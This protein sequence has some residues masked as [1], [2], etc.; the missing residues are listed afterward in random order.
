MTAAP[1]P[2]GRDQPRP[3]RPE[4]AARGRARQ[5]ARQ[6][7]RWAGR[8]ALA[9]LALTALGA[10]LLAIAVLGWSYPVAELA[11]ERGGPLL[12]TDRNGRLLRSVPGP[13]HRPGRAAWVP[14]ERVPSHALLAVIASEDRRFYEHSGV[15]VLGVLRAAWLDVRAGRLAY[16]GSTITMQLVRMVDP[17]LRTRG[18][19]SKIAQAVQAL[20]LERAVDKRFLLEQYLNRAY[21]GNG[22][23][24]LEAAARLYFDKPAASLSAGEATLLAV[25]PRAPSAYDPVRHLDAALRRRAHVLGLIAAR[26]WM[27]AAEV[28]RAAAQPLA[29]ALHQPGFRAPHFVEMVIRS[30]PAEVRGRGGVVRTTL[31]VRLQEALEHRVREHVAGLAERRLQQAGVLVL[32]T[33][34]GQVLALVGSAGLDGGNGHVDAVTWRRYP[35]SA[36]KPFVYA[37]AIERGDSPATIAYDIHD[38]PSAYRVV[39]L[40]QP[41]RGPVTYREALAGS[42]NLAAVHVLERVGVPALM[43]VLARAGAGELVG[44]ADDYGLRLALGAAKVRLL[45]LASAYGFLVRGGRVRSPSFVFDVRSDD[46]RTWR[47][48]R[49]VERAVFSP[50][51]SWLVMDMLADPVAR[52]RVFGRE[53]PLDLPFPVAAKTGTA[54]GFSDTVAIGVT[55]ELTV[56]AW[57]GNFDGEATEGLIAMQSAAPLVRAGLLLGARERMLTLP[58]APA[59]VVEADVCALSGM[60]PSADCPHTM[61]EHFRAGGAPR[62]VCTWHRREQ[63]RLVVSYPAEVRAWAERQRTRGGRHLLGLR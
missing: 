60:R 24:G 16:G 61:R 5:V 15:D 7:A 12:V 22:A 41:E 13:A 29:P 9:G 2:A 36:L 46:G 17:D 37:L 35:G 58:E 39:H 31:D 47:P 23:Y 8:A 57:A 27:S 25:I 28:E 50:E 42:Y 62:E 6:V 34:R 20:R 54:R 53:L 52:R 45:D 10:L 3:A 49:P 4:G 44:D 21:Y 48:P 14:L 11:P 18:L 40:T 19:A 51:T 1:R 56:A 43:H 32:D 30:L 59:G 38:V 33:R 55:S 26:G 63:G